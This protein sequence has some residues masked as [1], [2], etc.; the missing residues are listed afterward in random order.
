MTSLG[1]YFQE[2]TKNRLST[3]SQDLATGGPETVNNPVNIGPA[4]KVLAINNPAV[5]NPAE[6]V[7]KLDKE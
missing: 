3:S 1:P 6:L 4:V 7:A 2:P 5:N